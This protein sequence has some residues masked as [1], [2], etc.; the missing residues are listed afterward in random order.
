M[1]GARKPPLAPSTWIGTSRPVSAWSSSSASATSF[2]GLVVARER[3]AEGRDDAD[4]VLVDPL[5]HLLG[6]HDQAVALHRDL[7]VLDAPVARE[8]VPAD[9]DRA[10]HQVRLVDRACPPPAAGRASSRAGPSRRASRPRWSRSSTSPGCSRHRVSSTGRPGCA[11]SAPRARP[12]AGTRPCRSCSCRASGPSAGGPRA[13]ATSGRTSPGSA[14]SCRR[15]A[16]RPPRPGRRASGPAPCRGSGTWA[17][18]PTGRWRRTRRPPTR[19]GPCPSRAASRSP[20]WRLGYLVGDGNGNPGRPGAPGT[21]QAGEPGQARRHDRAD[22]LRQ[23]RTEDR[24]HERHGRVDQE[25]ADRRAVEL[26]VDRL[27]EAEPGLGEQGAEGAEVRVEDDDRG[28]DQ[29]Q[30][31]DAAEDRAQHLVQAA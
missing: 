19:R 23:Q 17:S 16:A 14:A 12:S 31:L 18:T 20:G 30:R 2:D 9:L 25:L 8:L 28:R 15:A 11:R 27:E 29:Q 7:A 13:P 26:L 1:N 6:V 5:E 3:H 10:R 21:R 24:E 4:G 22:V